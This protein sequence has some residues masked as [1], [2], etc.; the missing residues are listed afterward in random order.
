MTQRQRQRREVD[1]M[2][3]GALIAVGALAVLDNVVV[4]WLLGWHRLV[5]GWPHGANL[6]AE[7]ALV[8]LGL[9]MLGAGL[10]RRRQSPRTSP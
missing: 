3:D 6:A 10:W 4:H 9:A 7:V 8:V 1:A 2:I 5:E